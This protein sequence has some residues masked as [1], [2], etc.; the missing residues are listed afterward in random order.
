MSRL[1]RADEQPRPYTF[2]D[3]NK[4]GNPRPKLTDE[5]GKTE[6][7]RKVKVPYILSFHQQQTV[8]AEVRQGRCP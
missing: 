3:E 7:T 4:T 8:V 2:S 1:P 5:Q 6:E